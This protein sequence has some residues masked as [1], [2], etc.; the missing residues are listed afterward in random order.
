MNIDADEAPILLVEDDPNDVL[1]I[2][3]AFERARVLNPL[4]VVGDGDEAVEYLSATGRHRDR[5]ER[6]W[7]ALVLLDLKL[8]RR[9]GHEVLR[10]IRWE[11]G[12][13]D[14]PVV[15]LSSST[16]QA[17]VRRAY[18]LGANSYLKKPAS[19]DS[20]QELIRTLDLYWVMLNVRPDQRRG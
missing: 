20:L 11:A 3:R 2:R 13:T 9:S 8:P 1:L 5:A 4:H 6:G 12:L 17:D 15:V 16:E 14:L 7:P 19:F 10:W 18:E